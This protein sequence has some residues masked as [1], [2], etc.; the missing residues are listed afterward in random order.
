MPCP[1]NIV[2]AFFPESTDQFIIVLFPEILDLF[3]P[4]DHQ[5]KRRGHD[6][7]DTERIIY[8]LFPGLYGICAG[9][10]QP[11]QPV[12]PFPA[13][14]CLIHVTAGIV[15]VQLVRDYAIKRFLHRIVVPRLYIDTFRRSFVF[16]IDK[17]L[18][19]QELSLT[20]R[21]SAVH[22][23]IR[24][25]QKF[26]DRRQLFPA[27]PLGSR[28][29]LPFLR[30][31]RIIC[32]VCQTIIGRHGH[33]QHMPHGPCN[34]NIPFFVITGFFKRGKLP[35]KKIFRHDIRYVLLFRNIQLH[36]TP[37]KN[38]LT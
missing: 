22:H 17:D 25:L 11:D 30:E 8:F 23:N 26:P 33:L 2:R 34:D 37:P 38:S 21:V 24:C 9:Q 7:P 15:T 35:S 4:P 10:V 5:R 6:T 32:P 19:H 3:F 31:H 1:D 29:L 18:I 27:L 28:K 16:E 14:S 13:I 36:N 12:G 20:V